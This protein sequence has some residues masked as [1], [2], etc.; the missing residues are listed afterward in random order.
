MITTLSIFKSFHCLVN[1]D[2]N[3]YAG[4]AAVTTHGD[5]NG[6]GADDTS[7]STKVG[8]DNAGRQKRVLSKRNSHIDVVV[9]TR[10]AVDEALGRGEYVFDIHGVCRCG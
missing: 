9:L 5:D 6:N 10:R 1:D 4:V 7:S 3:S 8:G 2:N